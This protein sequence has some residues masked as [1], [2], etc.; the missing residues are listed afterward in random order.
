MSPSSFKELYLVHLHAC[1]F[2]TCMLLQIMVMLVL[3]VLHILLSHVDSKPI[4]S[5]KREK[6]YLSLAYISNLNN[7]N[8]IF[9]L[10]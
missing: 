5:L 4:T 7:I 1:H 10:T 3:N 9:Y 6:R 8:A 2:V